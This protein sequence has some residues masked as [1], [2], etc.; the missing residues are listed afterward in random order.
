MKKISLMLLAGILAVNLSAQSVKI[1][2]V[3]VQST[4]STT[5]KPKAK[6]SAIKVANQTMATITKDRI[7]ITSSNQSIAV[8]L[9]AYVEQGVTRYMVE[10]KSTKTFKYLQ[11]TLWIKKEFS[12]KIACYMDSVNTAANTSQFEIKKHVRK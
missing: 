11:Y 4:T 1:K 3:Q 7:K 12:D 8:G 6:D 9:L 10:E 5:S 2:T